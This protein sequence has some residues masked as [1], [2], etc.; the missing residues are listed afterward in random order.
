M[1]FG[2]RIKGSDGDVLNGSYR[3]R[4]I[5]LMFGVLVS[6]KVLLVLVSSHLLAH[7]GSSGQEQPVANHL[8]CNLLIEE[9]I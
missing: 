1:P 3:M 7:R 9:Q 8:D 6:L 2:S 4:R 5:S